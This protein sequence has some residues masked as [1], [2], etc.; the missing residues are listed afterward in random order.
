[1]KD[2]SRH[3]S[4]TVEMAMES[5]TTAIKKKLQ[6]RDFAAAANI[7]IITAAELWRDVKQEVLGA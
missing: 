2:N 5:V 4:T 6:A 7:K 3:N 1:M